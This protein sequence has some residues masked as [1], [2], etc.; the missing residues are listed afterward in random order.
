MNRSTPAPA[1]AGTMTSRTVFAIVLLAVAASFGLRGAKVYAE[2]ANADYKQGQAAEAREDYD[3][4]FDDYQKALKKNP[5]DTQFKIALAR[6]RVTASSVHVSN[7]RKLERAGDTQGALGEFLHAAEID[8]SN[9]AAQQ[10]IA[11]LRQKQGENAPVPDVGLPEP[12][13]E[14][15]QLQSIESPPQLKPV[16]NE[17]LSLHMA[18]DSKVV[19]ETVGKAAGVNVLFDPD[20]HSTRIE[21]DLNNVSLL[22][23][24]RIVSVMSNTFWRPVTDNTIF[25]AQNTPTKRRDL[26]EQAVQTFYLTNAWQQND[27]ND[28]ATAI[29]NV[30]TGIK[31]FPVQSQNAIVIRGTPDELLLAQQLI[32]DLDKP[33]GEVVV[34]I[35]VLEVSKNWEKTLG[36]QWPSSFGVALQPNC[37]GHQFL[38]H[39]QQ[40]QFLQLWHHDHQ[41][42]AV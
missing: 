3:T 31:A 13:A 29:R 27:L 10:E 16:S 17:P 22:D 19:Y 37:C 36:M 4:A 42:D 14:A 41:P 39:F 34:D 38:Q 5:K 20:Y 6:V 9:E 28:V 21:V 24:L 18:E 1:V 32:D 30:M 15:A 40:L 12:P 2:S 25:V 7:G 33:R 35:A 23:A 11:R 26:D 8:P